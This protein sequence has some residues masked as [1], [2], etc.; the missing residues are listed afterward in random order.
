MLLPFIPKSTLEA[1]I[2]IV[3]LE[4]LDFELP[5]CGSVQAGF[6]SPADDH[7]EQAMDLQELLIK[8]QACSFFVWVNGESMIEAGIYP[9]DLMVVDRSIEACHGNVVIPLINSEYTVKRLCKQQG[10]IELRPENPAFERIIIA[11]GDEL[12]IWGVVT[13]SLRLHRKPAVHGQ[14]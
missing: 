11:E 8:D 13:T 4:D 6:Q 2:P 7:T 12:I 9:G 10:R 5:L 14:S 1:Q 3:A